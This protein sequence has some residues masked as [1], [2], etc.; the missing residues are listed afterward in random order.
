MDN[1]TLTNL[2]SGIKSRNFIPAL[3][4]ILC[5][6]APAFAADSTYVTDI[7]VVASGARSMAMGRATVAQNLG[8]TAIF[9]NPAGTVNDS[10]WGLTS[11]STQLLHRVDY[12]MLSGT[13][14]I[15]NATCGIGYVSAATPAGYYT[16]DSGSLA[17]AQAI[18]YGDS[19]FALS[20]ASKLNDKIKHPKSIGD[21][22]VGASLKLLNR[23]FS[24]TG[25]EGYSGTGYAA[26]VGVILDNCTGTT[27]GASVNNLLSSLS[28]ASGY[29]ETLPTTI[30][31]GGSRTLL[32]NNLTVAAEGDFTFSST[33]MTLHCGAEYTPFS[34]ISVRA[35]VDQVAS[36]SGSDTGAASTNLTA[37]LGINFEGFAFDYA[38]RHDSSLSDNMTHYFSISYSPEPLAKPVVQK[39]AAEN[40]YVETSTPAQALKEPPAQRKA[41]TVDS[42]LAE[43]LELDR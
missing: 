12:K 19:Q 4:L 1:K 15:G 7:S 41:A 31:L 18:S 5:L 10:P 11:M 8:A 23:G 40:E 30:K 17:S 37:G 34:F 22:S 13:Y 28:W 21:L 16:T 35:G 20:Y 25:V 29:T 9:S 42:D 6:A 14:N 43:L 38:Y 24:G 26:D 36:T 32:E 3:V 27:F 33:P 39:A 2:I